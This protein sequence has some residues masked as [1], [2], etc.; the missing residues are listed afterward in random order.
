MN[1]CYAPG[2]RIT[3]GTF[4]QQNGPPDRGPS[5]IGIGRR[6]TPQGSVLSSFLFNA[7]MTGLLSG[8]AEAAAMEGFRRDC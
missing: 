6:G 5:A 8:S 1:P 3:L 4:V 2:L 7:A